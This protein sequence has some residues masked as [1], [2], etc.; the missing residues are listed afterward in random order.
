MEVE[1]YIVATDARLIEMV[2]G[3]DN[4]AFE[5]LFNR[6][7]GSLQQIYLLRTGGNSDDTSDLIQ[8]IFVKAYLKLE[9]YDPSYTFGQWIYTIAKNTFIDYV[10]KR[11]DNLSFDSTRGE[12]AR[13]P[14]STTP[15]PEEDIIN[16]EQRGMLEMHL[17]KMP[18]KYRLLS[19]LRF[20]KDLSYEE[21][22][23]QLGLPLGTVK[24]QIHR[25]RTQLRDQ[26][27]KSGI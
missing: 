21:I 12:F 27:A 1:K 3:G 2:V 11:R 13:Q 23:G 18:P 10:R 14:V 22:A 24:T 26:I 20:F 8:E 4:R 19:E 7:E 9:S 16:A 15:N 25:A 17:E 5:H 6:Y